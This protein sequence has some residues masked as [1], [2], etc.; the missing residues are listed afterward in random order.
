M[1]KNDVALVGLDKIANH[2]GNTDGKDN[3]DSHLYETPQGEKIR[4]SYFVDTIT[5]TTAPR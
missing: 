4:S 3:D 5:T 1:C 2:S